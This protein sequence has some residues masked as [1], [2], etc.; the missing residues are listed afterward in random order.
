MKSESGPETQATKFLQQHG[1]VY[2]SH[3]YSYEEHGGHQCVC[4]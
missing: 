1:V 4:A 2:S 3:L